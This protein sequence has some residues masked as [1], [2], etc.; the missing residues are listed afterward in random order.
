MDI[1]PNLLKRKEDNMAAQKQPTYY[2]G[3]CDGIKYALKAMNKHLDDTKG[4]LSKADL[5][6]FIGFMLKT[7][8]R[9]VTK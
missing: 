9:G 1:K 8:E 6:F 5:K 3:W 7:T 2:D 4:T